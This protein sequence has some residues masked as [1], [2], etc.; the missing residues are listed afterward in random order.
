MKYSELDFKGGIVTYDLYSMYPDESEH[1]S[2]GF[3]SQDLLVINYGK[4]TI[5]LGH[6]YTC[7]GISII[8]NSEKEWKP[9]YTLK[10]IEHE[11]IFDSLQEVIN[12]AEKLFNLKAYI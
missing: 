4:F 3:L 1:F 10:V 2:K 11:K 6:Y 7:Y 5:D 8:D 12:N 9:F